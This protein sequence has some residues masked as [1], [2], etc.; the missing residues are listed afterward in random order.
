MNRPHLSHRLEHLVVVSVAAVVIRLP[1][2][3]AVALGAALGW[4]AGSLLRIRRG[5]VRENLARAFP[6]RSPSWHRR[7]TRASYRH[8]GREVV[9]LIRFGHMLPAEVRARC[10]V[11]GLEL[12]Q[13][14]LA[15]GQSVMVLAGH[16][17]NW[18]I[19]GVSLTAWGIPVDAVARRQ[20]NPLFDE[21]VNR[22]R[23]RLGLGVIYQHEAT[24]RV[25]KCLRDSR[26]IA[27]VADQNFTGE[28][29]FVDF[30]GFPAST[31]RGPGVLAIRTGVPV[32]F[33]DPRRLPGSKVRYRVRLSPIVYEPADDLE[34][35]VRRLTGAYVASL[36]EVIRE[37]P[38]QYFWFHKRWK[39]QPE[40]RE[41]GWSAQVA[42]GAPEAPSQAEHAQGD[43]D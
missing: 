17:G 9:S 35:D 41:P 16:F 36:E 37:N 4:I 43:A 31:V 38:E 8:F 19:G 39:T 28:G 27:L 21:Y 40:V 5:V 32:L 30:F 34:E 3:A 33:A 11:E 7:V 23:G 42:K 15:R 14:P 18:E 12:I 29:V 22:A 1:E 24:R 25:M 26:V 13:G 2:A 10:E 20:S 6:E